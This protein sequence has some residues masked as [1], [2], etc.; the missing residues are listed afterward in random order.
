MTDGTDFGDLEISEPYRAMLR[1]LDAGPQEV[2][3]LLQ[4]AITQTYQQYDQQ[5][6]TEGY[7]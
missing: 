7:E 2:S 6:R 3:V 1:E 5:R 4:D